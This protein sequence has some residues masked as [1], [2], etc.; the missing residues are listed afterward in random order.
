MLSSIPILAIRA[1]EAAARTGSFRGAANELRV[2]PSAISHSIRKLEGALGTALFERGVRQVYL[3]PQG[4]SLRRSAVAAFDE[5]RHGLE[6][7]AYRGNQRLRVHCAPSFAAQWLN[8]RL[9]RFLD[10]HPRIDL[11]LAAGTDYARFTNDDFDVDIVYGPP[12]AE[13]MEVIGLGE[14]VVTPLCAPALAPRIQTPHDLL[15]H[16]LIT[17][18]N[19]LVRWHD[20]FSA[21]AMAAPAVRGMLF[22]RSFLA[23]ATAAA[24]LGVALEST[25]L[26]EGEI[27]SGRLVA[28][29]AGRSVDIRYVGHRI[30]L[31]RASAQGGL[32]G[33]FVGWVLAELGLPE[34]RHVDPRRALH[35]RGDAGDRA[36]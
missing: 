18:E 2:S 24:G 36:G 21:N 34:H 31:P 4:E 8:P 33:A 27:A 19:K 3:T 9:S 11:R 5:L 15:A 25:R 12:R 23:I 16:V 14:E 26:A 10:A 13:T 30:V 22:D 28:P 1:F 32:V 20:W 6:Q 17:S 29:L 7:V 35:P